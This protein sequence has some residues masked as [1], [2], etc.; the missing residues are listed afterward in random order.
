MF[1]YILGSVIIFSALLSAGKSDVSDLLIFYTLVL[2]FLWDIR[3]KVK[4][5]ISTL[6]ILFI[7]GSLVIF[8][9]PTFFSISVLTSQQ[10]VRSWLLIVLFA[11]YTR[12][13]FHDSPKFEKLITVLIIFPACL[14]VV[15]FVVNLANLPHPTSDINLIFPSYGHIRYAEFFLPIFPVSVYLFL[16]SGTSKVLRTASLISIIYTVF[17]FSRASWMSMIIVPAI[18]PTFMKANRNLSKVF[19][20]I[21]LFIVIF[22]S[23][24]YKVWSGFE[25]H[26]PNTFRFLNIINKPLNVEPRLEYY[27]FT[28]SK[29]L[30]SPI[31]GYGP[32]TFFYPKTNLFSG[33]SSTIFVHN[34]VLQKLYE[35]GIPG[36]LI[37][38]GFLMW[39]FLNAFKNTKNDEFGRM[40]SLGV[41][42]S[43]IQAQMDFGWE[44]PIVYFLNL[45]ILFHYQPANSKTHPLVSKAYNS[46]FLVLIGWTAFS[47]LSYKSTS[48]KFDNL[49][50]KE[51]KSNFLS[52]SLVKQ[53][54]I[55]DIGNGK[56]YANLSDKEFIA[57]NYKNALELAFKSIN[58]PMYPNI[59][60]TKHLVRFL[61]EPV[62]SQ[63]DNKSVFRILNHISTTSLPHDFYWVKPEED[64]KTIFKVVNKLLDRKP[65]KDID[66][67]NLAKIYYWKFTGSV[68]EIK[69]IKAASELDPNNA[70]YKNIKEISEMVL[71]SSKLNTALARTQESLIPTPQRN[72]YISLLDLIYSRIADK[73]EKEGDVEKELQTRDDRLSTTHYRQAYVSYI[74]RL[75]RLKKQADA[76]KL[77]SECKTLYAEC[78]E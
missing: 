30:K 2:I 70:E 44:I 52:S 54:I 50:S 31:L 37:Y 67:K 36:G 53:W 26:K 45:L 59:I 60:S 19:L 41:V 42:I 73:L 17:T 62:I 22:M 20:V 7:L 1:Q 9:I 5:K 3:H 78:Q 69:Y 6:I 16:R 76:E 63:L 14:S 4:Y 15:S 33:S 64:K 74:S 57:G 75:I 51:V 48:E 71:D 49:V 39:L 43:F 23:S 27:K 72:V 35:L 47:S 77:L 21:S 61:A 12:N 18:L 29:I 38:I 13:I 24:L 11:L 68:S 25:Y 40:L 66:N 58:S 32:G 55:L 10:T 65:I 34:H 46:L 8:I 56:M 28:I